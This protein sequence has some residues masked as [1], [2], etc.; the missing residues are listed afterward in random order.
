MI[1]PAYQQ[2]DSSLVLKWTEYV[3]KGGNLI[4][5]CR[6]GHKDREMHLWQARFA[7]PIYDLIGAEIE[8]Y[9]LPAAYDPDTVVMGRE[10]YPW[11]SWGEML[12]PGSGTETWAKYSGDF[13]AGK[14]AVVHRKMGKGS[15]TYV[16]A[17]SREG[18]LERDVLRKVFGLSGIHV[19]DYPPGVMVEYRD[20]FG[21]AVNYS[22]R[23]YSLKIP[24]NAEILVGS[25]NLKPAGVVVWK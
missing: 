8:Y 7:A 23:D 6:T 1:V 13:Y 2:L 25:A 9:D 4:L 24:S 18:L 14:A 15:V 16:G 11:N 5:S 20:G 19:E 3:K 17:D 21:I 12:K 22:D 10:K